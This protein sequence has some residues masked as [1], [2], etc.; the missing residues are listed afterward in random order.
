M[1][2]V[3]SFTS[4]FTC[5]ASTCIFKKTVSRTVAITSPYV[6]LHEALA[7]M[8][9]NPP[10]RSGFRDCASLARNDEDCASLEFTLRE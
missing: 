2:F 5:S 10:E 7:P 6:T 9:Q 8:L 1:R 3:T 4:F